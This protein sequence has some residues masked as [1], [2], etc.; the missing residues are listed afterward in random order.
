MPV[1]FGAALRSLLAAAGISGGGGGDP[2]GGFG[3]ADYLLLQDTGSDFN[4]STDGLIYTRAGDTIGLEPRADKLL[5]E[6]DESGFVLV[7]PTAGDELLL[8]TAE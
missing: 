4:E 5:L 6:G 2:G 7:T 8:E 1:G 3:D